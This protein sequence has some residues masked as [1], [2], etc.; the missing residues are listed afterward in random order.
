MS[1]SVSRSIP[2]L[3]EGVF[4]SRSLGTTQFSNVNSIFPKSFK[5]SIM[6]FERERDLIVNVLKKVVRHGGDVI[7]RMRSSLWRK[8]GWR[9]LKRQICEESTTLCPFT[10]LVVPS[11]L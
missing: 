6:R 7:V 3:A 2:S 11:S 9:S 8:I 1:I 10:R 4:I 5:G